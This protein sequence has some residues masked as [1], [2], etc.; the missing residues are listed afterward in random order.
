MRGRRGCRRTPGRCRAAAHS[1]LQRG[2]APLQRRGVAAQTL[3]AQPQETQLRV[4]PLA[5]AVRQ[6]GGGTLDGIGHK[7]QAAHGHVRR[8]IGQTLAVVYA[9]EQ[10][11]AALRRGLHHRHI[12]AQVAKLAQQGCHVLAAAVQLVKER[13]RVAALPCQQQP[14][15]LQCLGASGQAQRVQH[16]AGIHRGAGGAALI[17]QAQRVAQSAVGH[18]RQQLRSVARQVDGLRLRH[19]EK[20]LLHV[21][22]Q[23]PLEGEALAPGQNGGGHLLQLGGGQN[24][25][26]VRRRLLHDLQQGVEGVLGEHVYLVD[27]IHALFQHRGRV[28]GLLPQGAGIVHAAVGGSVQLGHVQQRSVVDAPAGGALV[29]GRAVHG[30]LAVDGLGQDPGAGGLSGAPGAGEQVGVPH[31]TVGHLTL[32]RVGDVLLPHH[33]GE[34]LG[35]IFAIERLIHG[36]TSPAD[37][38]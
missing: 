28:D 24:E 19:P 9:A 4:R 3:V 6:R 20:L 5:D 22:G 38:K 21:V 25:Q 18:P 16:G 23:D 33:L 30:M 7:Q 17:Q 14:H 32:Q 34:G 26:Q 10:R 12:P 8:H 11:R 35:A 31:L 2:N 36:H 1:V 27:D 13:Q 37:A 15:E 29:A